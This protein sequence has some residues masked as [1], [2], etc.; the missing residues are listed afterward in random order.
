MIQDYIEESLQK[1]NSTMTD[2]LVSEDELMQEIMDYV[3]SEK[4]KQLRSRM[5]LSVAYY[6]NRSE[7]AVLYASMIEVIHMASLVHDDVIDE[8][9]KRRGRE[10]VQAKYG[11]KMAVYAG[12]FMLFS[13]F[14][15]LYKSFDR[16]FVF[17][18]DSLN[19]VCYGE[20]GQSNYMFNPDVTVDTYIDNIYG[21][22]AVAFQMACK[23]GAVAT[24]ISKADT[25]RFDDFGKAFGILFQIRDDLLDYQNETEVQENR[26]SRI[27]LREFIQFRLFY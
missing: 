2:A 5:L 18:V 8:S 22:T 9:E 7:K 12:D 14:S 4:G 16:K 27:L 26:V 19:K 3:L 21:K 6:G 24:R 10:S 15:N 11:K 25:Q 23:A 20:L 1:I 13:C 17:I